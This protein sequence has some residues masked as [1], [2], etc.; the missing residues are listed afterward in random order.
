[1]PAANL[2]SAGEVDRFVS[3]FRN[4]RDRGL[5]RNCGDYAEQKLRSRHPSE[6]ESTIRSIRNHGESAVDY[7]NR[8]NQSADRTVVGTSR[9]VDPAETQRRGGVSGS[10][11][12]RY[13]ATVSVTISG[14]PNDGAV[15]PISVSVNSR[16]PLTAGEIRESAAK[17]AEGVAD[18][19]AKDSDRLAGAEITVSAEVRINSA[20]RDRR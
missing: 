10:I 20:Y 8:A 6:S 11:N 19:Y 18:A 1:M 14:G 13:G 7:G 17:A 5:S 4:C 16:D 12:Y 2:I 9:G 3:D 15:F